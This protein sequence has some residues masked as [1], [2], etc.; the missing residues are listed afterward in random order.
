MGNNT[1]IILLCMVGHLLHLLKYQFSYTVWIRLKMQNKWE[2]SMMNIQSKDRRGKVRVT[3]S[4]TSYTI[5]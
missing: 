1:R 2:Q 4:Y 3:P 5:D